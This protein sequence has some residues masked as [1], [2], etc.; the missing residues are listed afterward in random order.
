M[1]TNDFDYDLPP[2]LI[3]R[4]PTAQRDGSRLLVLNKETSQIEDHSFPNLI[5]FL[6]P[7]DL[8]IF[9]DSKVMSARLYGKKETGGAVELLIERI[10]SK[11][12]ILAHI[13]SNK[14][15]KV[16]SKIYIETLCLEV[17]Y[18]SDTLYQ[19]KLLEG[20]IWKVMQKFGHVPLPPYINRNDE[21][22]DLDRYQTVYC[23]DYGSVAAPTAGL[24]FT[25]EMIYKIEQKGIST[26]YLTLHVGSGTFQPVKVDDVTQ[27]KMHEEYIEVSE[28]VCQLIHQTK[29]QGGRVVAVGTTTVR[30]L[31]TSGLSG[32][33]TPFFGPTNIFLYP[34]KKFNIVDAIVTN[35][36]LP[37]STLI[38]LI[39]AF[40]SKSLILNAYQHAI[41]NHYRFY[42]YG[43]SMLIV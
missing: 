3:A 10:E 28:N 24:H 43:D 27:H 33:A 25:K 35:F 31:E 41:D 8:L 5:D 22:L 19:L 40:S 23:Q 30:S 34:G 1:N 36:H 20:D 38:M 26:A 21:K 42:S 16:G 13:R 9:N 2:E 4:Y 12:F 39:S 14:S 37:K 18:K 29:K 7:G 32:V 6:K 11:E 15:P 17:C